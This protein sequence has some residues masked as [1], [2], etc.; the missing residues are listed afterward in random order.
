M[1]KV[2]L[3]NTNKAYLPEVEAY[4]DFF[5]N[6]TEY[7]FFDSA[8]LG[9]YDIKDYDMIWSFMGF[10]R[11]KHDR[12][13][14]HDYASLSTGNFAHIKDFI[15][16]NMNKKPALRL[17]LN[18]YVKQGFGFK[19][20][21]PSVMRDMGI[22]ESFFSDFSPKK[23]YDFVYVGAINKSR[24]TDKLL[25]KFKNEYKNQTLLVIGHVEKEWMDT[26]RAPN[27]IFAGRLNYKEVAQT[28]KLAHYGIN[29]IPNKYPYNLQT[30]TK[31]LEYLAMGLNVVTNEYQWIKDFEKSKNINLF[32]MDENLNIDF[33]K[34]ETFHFKSCDMKDFMWKNVL[35]NSGMKEAL[36]K[37]ISGN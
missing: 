11:E 15:K 27:I 29:Y 30:S 36:D 1:I 13:R 5:N 21:A 7:F 6:Q 35:L 32:K 24:R 8:E 18:Q 9:M 17:F 20:G 31:L 26:F 3:T 33:K 14:I 23:E 28:A 2:L 4:K 19:D 10:D 25:A 16:K 37:L 34:L 22:S 12:I